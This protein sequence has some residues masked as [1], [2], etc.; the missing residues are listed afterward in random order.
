MIKRAIVLLV[1]A[2][3]LAAGG[4]GWKWQHS[5]NSK[6]NYR[7]A[8]WTWGDDAARWSGDET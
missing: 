5:G 2:A 4:A 3:A 1:V 6:G 7:I 8:G